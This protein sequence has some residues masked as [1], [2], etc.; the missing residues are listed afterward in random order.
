ME[1]LQQPRQLAA[2]EHDG[3]ATLVPELEWFRSPI[4]L[5]SDE[6]HQNVR[7]PQNRSCQG[8]H[9]DVPGGGDVLAWRASPLCRRGG[10]MAA[11]LLCCVSLN[12]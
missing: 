1:L 2:A 10:K 3:Q 12:F 11:L 6:V 7:S 5:L 4:E 9:E 8:A